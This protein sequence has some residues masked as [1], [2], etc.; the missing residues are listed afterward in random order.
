MGFLS[1]VFVL[2]TSGAA[3]AN[4]VAAGFDL[5]TTPPGGAFHDFSADPIPADF[6]YPGSDPFTS[7]VQLQ[8]NGSGTCG[9]DTMVRR[10]ANATL[11]V[12]GQDTIPIEIVELSLVSAVPITVTGINPPEPWDV[13]VQLSPN[14]QPLGSMTIKHQVADGGTYDSTLPVCPLFTF[15][16]Q[17]FPFDVRQIDT[18]FEAIPPVMIGTGAAPW[19]H[20]VITPLVCPQVSTL[21]FIAGGPHTGPHPDAQPLEDVVPP[22]IPVMGPVGLGVFA[23]LLVASLF[24]VS[25]RRG[26][27]AD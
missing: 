12:G 24:F 25:R 22:P 8:G 16:Q 23:L 26:L 11:P 2:V 19:S 18:C 1:G 5:W 10:L 7:L 13:Q 21:N 9:S 14:P 27:R 20:L 17:V 6:F 15:V 4:D 3:S